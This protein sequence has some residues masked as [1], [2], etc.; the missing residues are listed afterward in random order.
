MPNATW[1]TGCNQPREH[2]AHWPGPH[3]Y[4]VLRLL[5]GIFASVA[6]T[7]SLV[8]LYNVLCRATGL[9][10]RTTDVGPPKNVVGDQSDRGRVVTVQ[11]TGTVMPGLPWDV[12]PRTRTLVVHPGDTHV[13]QFLARNLSS[14]QTSSQAIP[15]ITPGPAANFFQKIECFCFV[16]QSMPPHGQREMVIVFTV[17]PDLDQDIK[18]LTLAYAFFPLGH[19][20]ASRRPGV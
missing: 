16:H 8:P 7:V 17:H 1:Q 13:V 14:E 6:F 5:L 19:P 15:G 20:A 11:F 3:R 9:N 10:G 2:S 18:V 4:L 12:K